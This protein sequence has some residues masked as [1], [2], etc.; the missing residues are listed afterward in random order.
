[1]PKP[2][3]ELTADDIKEIVAERVSEGQYLDF[4]QNLSGR[5][6]TGNDW[7]DGATSIAPRAVNELARSLVAFAN[8][9]GGW[10]LLGICE[11]NDRPHHAD[12]ITPLRACDELAR[13]LRQSLHERIDPIPLGLDARGIDTDG[14]GGGVVVLRMPASSSAPHGLRTDHGIECY[15]RRNDECRPMTMR[16]IQERTLDIT[17]SIGAV[18][19]LFAERRQS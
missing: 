16:D 6:N 5:G 1:M 13:R 14:V 11:A 9:E 10:V 8:A 2:L 18:E 15:I 12:S 7:N 19:A 3:A 17:R 4:K